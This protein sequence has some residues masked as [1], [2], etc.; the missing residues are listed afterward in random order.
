M[1]A[2]MRAAMVRAPGAW[3]AMIAKLAKSDLRPSD[4][5]AAKRAPRGFED[6]ADEEIAAA[7]RLKSIIC[8]RPIAG[9]ALSGVELIA[10]LTAFAK[11][12]LPLLEWGWPAVVD[13]R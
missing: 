2:R 3:K 5:H 1:L 7:L 6:V 13:S 11:D 12:V 9:D 8:R 10:H 4:E